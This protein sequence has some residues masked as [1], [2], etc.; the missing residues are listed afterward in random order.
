MRFRTCISAKKSPSLNGNYP[1]LQ[2][3]GFPRAFF[4][5]ITG[6]GH[7]DS[8]VIHVCHALVPGHHGISPQ[9]RPVYFGDAVLNEVIAKRVHCSV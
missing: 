2:A 5:L 9:V 1:I 8:P 3:R 4:F 7:R 6:S